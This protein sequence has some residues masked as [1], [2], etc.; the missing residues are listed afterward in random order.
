MLLLNELDSYMLTSQLINTVFGK[1][2]EKKEKEKEKEEDTIFIPREKDSLFWCFFIMKY[3]DIE[4][5]IIQEQNT[6]IFVTEKKLKIDYVEKLR[7]EKQLVK[8]YKFA[9]LSEIENQLANEQKINVETFFTLCLIEKI[10]VLYVN[11]K[12]FFELTIESSACTHIVR[13]LCTKG[14]RV[15]SNNF[16]VGYE[17]VNEVKAGSYRSTLYKLEDLNKPI[18]SLASYKVND[19]LSIFAKLGVDVNNKMSKKEL[20]EKLVISF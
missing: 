19:I 11:N 2:R 13:R 3:G 8:E 14:Y 9:A 7:K 12:T 18:K 10:N 15:N 1:T 4:Y 17:G 6:N 16:R 5:E 20:Y